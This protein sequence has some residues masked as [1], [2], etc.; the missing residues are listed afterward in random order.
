MNIYLICLF[1]WSIVTVP[2]A[3]LLLS[4]QDPCLG[5]WNCQDK[6]PLYVFLGIITSTFLRTLRHERCP[7]PCFCLGKDV[8]QGKLGLFTS[9][10]SLPTI[11]YGRRV[12]SMFL[13]F[14]FKKHKELVFSSIESLI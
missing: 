3:A 4:E 5:L 1:Q 13:L 10:G 14:S 8:Q 6:F 12:Y 11:F 2:M 7:K 9:D